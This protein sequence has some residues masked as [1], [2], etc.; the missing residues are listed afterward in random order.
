[1]EYGSALK[2]NEMS[3]HEKTRRTLTCIFLSERSHSAKATI[4]YESNCVAFGKRKNRGD[5]KTVTV[6]RG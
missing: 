5:N 4:L 3:S 2:R 1:M 6:A